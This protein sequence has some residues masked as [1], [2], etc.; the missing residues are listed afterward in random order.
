M[1]VSF[2][3]S[4]S[5][6]FSN[7][8]TT[9]ADALVSVSGVPSGSYAWSFSTGVS[10]GGSTSGG[11]DGFFSTP[12]GSFLINISGL[13]AST[14][15][16]FTVYT[17]VNA[18]VSSTV[19]TGSFTT[20]APAPTTYSGSWNLGGGSGGG[21]YPTSV[22]IGSSIAAPTSNP[23][24][25]GYVFNGWSVSFPYTPTSSGWTISANWTPYVPPPTYPPATFTG[26]VGNGTVGTAYSATVTTTNMNYSGTWS[27][28]AGLPPGL[29][30][31][32]T[33][34]SNT[35]TLS[36]TPTTANTYS[37]S[38]TA[39]NSYSSQTGNYTITIAAPST[40]PPVWSDSAL[41]NFIVNKVY[42]DGVTATNMSAYSGVYS[43]SAGSLPAGISFNTSTGA[44]TGT[45]TAAAA[46]SFTITATNTYGTIS[47]VFSGNVNG[48]MSYYDGSAFTKKTVKYY[49]G[50]AWTTGTVYVYNGSSWVATQ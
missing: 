43:V 48:G 25:G 33:A 7:I 35:N 45:P 37:F 26:T 5:I 11:S 19:F 22:T 20:S 46:Y 1:A 9:S 4:V 15:Y 41:A 40:F 50:S 14:A 29:S 30:W 36:G 8:T 2:G 47:Q 38:T 21:P 18:G 12:S 32:N 34:G 27:S 42:S 24:L 49:N 23:T 44:V 6:S 17:A 3:G 31:S 39:S 16:V 13:S 10:G 28:S